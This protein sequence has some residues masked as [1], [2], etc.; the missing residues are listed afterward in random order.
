MRGIV[1]KLGFCAVFFCAG[2]AW[3]VVAEAASASESLTS[4]LLFSGR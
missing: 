3:G 1:G 4:V 2:M